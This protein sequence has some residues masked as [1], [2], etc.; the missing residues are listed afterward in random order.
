MIATFSSPTDALSFALASQRHHTRQNQ[1]LRIGIH[2]TD[3]HPSDLDAHEGAASIAVHLAES[4][5]PGEVLVSDVVRQLVSS[6]PAFGYVD[7]GRVLLRGSAHRVH[8]WSAADRHDPSTELATVGRSEQLAAIDRLIS[9]TTAG[10]GAILMFEGEAGIGKTHLLREARARAQRAN[11]LVLEVAAEEVV[12]RSGGLLHGLIE[13]DQTRTAA[14]ARLAELLSYD[15]DRSSEAHDRS[16]AIIE[17]AGDLVDSLAARQ[18]FLLIADDLQWADDLSIAALVA[19]VRRVS[20]AP[21]GILGAFRSVPRPVLLDRLLD[22]ATAAGGHLVQLEGL[23]DRD[24]DALV[25]ALIGAAPGLSLRTRLDATAG[26]ALYLTE[27]LRAFEEAGELR[28]AGGVAEAVGTVL[29]TSLRDTLLRRLSWLGSEASELLRIASLLG[30]SFSLRDIAVVLNRSVL[31]VAAGLRDASQAGLIT[32]DGNRL[33]FRHDLLREAV[34]EQMLAPI[35]RDMHRSAA[36][37]LRTSGAPTEQIAEQFARGALPGDLEAVEWLDRAGQEIVRTAPLSAIRHWERALALLP[38]QSSQRPAIQVQLIEPLSWGGRFE[39]ALRI[40]TDLNAKPQPPDVEFIALRGAAI[41]A[42][43][44]GDVVAAAEGMRKAASAPG[45]SA[46]DAGRLRCL[47]TQFRSMTGEFDMA[48]TRGLL[49]LELAWAVEH[50]DPSVECAAL[51]ALAIA[52][53][54]AGHAH[55]AVALLRR[56]I[57]LVESGGAVAVSYPILEAFHAGTLIDLDL[58]DEA[59]EAAEATRRR[60]ESHGAHFVLPMLCAVISS[61][62]FYSGNWAEAVATAEASLAISEDTGNTNFVLYSRA[63]LARIALRRNDRTTAQAQLD[64]GMQHF[65]QGARFGSEWLFSAQTE[66]LALN[67]DA[68]TA[69]SMGEFLWNQTAPIRYLWGHRMHGIELVRR[70]VAAERV[71]LAE[72]VV[73]DLEHGATLASVPSATATALQSRALFANDADIGLEALSLYRTTP[74]R[75]A[76]MRCCLD[77]G[78]LLATAGRRREAIAV[79]REASALAAELE[80]VADAA[81]TRSALLALG[82]RRLAPPQRRPASGWAALTTTELEVVALVADGLTNREIGE[83]LH[84]SAR[85]AEAHLTH[86]FAKLSLATRTQLA[87]AH[88]RRP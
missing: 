21:V 7:R 32:G 75:P 70:A 33:M 66:L 42:A 54:V 62:N 17:A 48:T 24:R 73:K 76:L 65:G 44:Y 16:F 34:Y 81:E 77:V 56:G 61:A 40:A 83:R 67:G 64:A 35:R 38:E 72:Q 84:M 79:L 50:D 8:V 53:H 43:Q 1:P 55:E 47:A 63:V 51:Q 37:S 30:V 71:D 68:D 20:S 22:R 28:V 82:V 36:L 41:A 23:T 5:Q 9:T 2:I 31:D 14:R 52:E 49:D 15:F 69:L 3:M 57:E 39:E 11:V 88:Q 85:T 78:S 46:S 58:I 87:L 60:A 10:A 25:S 80:S 45:A 59:I 4:A 19:L 29:P 12:R 6:P 13:A 86:V 27:L 26:N 74:L 18:S